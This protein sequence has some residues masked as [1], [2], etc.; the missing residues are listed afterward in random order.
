MA[1]KLSLAQLNDMCK[2]A[3]SLGFHSG[4]LIHLD[5]KLS[6]WSKTEFT[7]SIVAKIF[8]H[9]ELAFEGAYGSISPG[10]L[11]DSLTVDTIYPIC[12]LTKPVIGTLLS[13][14]QE[15]GELDF[16]NPVRDY[17]PELSGDEACRIRIWH[18]LTHTSGLNDDDLHNYFDYVVKNDLSIK[19]DYDSHDSIVEGYHLIREKIGL[20]AMD[21]SN[22]MQD[23][24]F[25]S[26]VLKAKPTHLPRKVMAYCNTGYNILRHI[27]TRVSGMT[28]DEFAAKKLFGPLKM[29][30]SHFLFPDE[31]RSRFVTRPED[32][33][34]SGWLNEHV[35]KSEG[36]G[37]G[38]KSTVTDMVRFG[39]MFLNGGQLDG[40][41]ILSPA[42]VKELI[43]DH[44]ADIE[45]SVFNGDIFNSTWG[46]GWNVKGS[47][48]DD[49]GMLRSGASF[50]HSGFGCVKLMCDP[51]YDI[52]AAYF[53][54][55]KEDNYYKAANFYNMVIGAIMV[56]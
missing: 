36:G 44:N 4:R 48:K 47:K 28:I 19:I 35:F 31:K 52:A 14:L 32:F 38:L 23:E 17:I 49:A 16:N 6:V 3:E 39:Q 25:F 11:P 51:V 41:R 8:R 55:S 12:S 43:S 26:V 1:N 9:G 53:T 18:L 7:P 37:G 15:E 54:T 56:I 13:I 24:T 2:K 40:E 34:G 22:T 45:D 29:V 50:E 10:A 46:Y 5:Q 33:C 20:P 30:D 42:S 27:I 21:H